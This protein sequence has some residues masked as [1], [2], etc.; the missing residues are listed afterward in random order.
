LIWQ[1]V[2]I[3]LF[4]KVNLINHPELYRLLEPGESIEDLLKLPIEQIL[5]RWVNYHLKNAGWDKKVN[6]FVND[7][8]DGTAY[9]VLLAQIAPKL[10]DRSPLSAPND[11]RRAEMVLENA[12]KL[13]CRKFVRPRDIVRGNQKLNL[14]FIANLFN[15]WPALEP[16]EEVIEIIEETREEKTFR[17]WMNSLGVNPFVNNLYID[18]RDGQ[19]LLQLF[20]QVEPGSVN[21]SK[22]N[23]DPQTTWKRLE[24]DNYAVDVGKSLKFSLVGIQGKDILDGNKTLTLAVVWQLMR[25]HVLSILRKL[26]GGQNISDNQI[27]EWANNKVA[28]S[29]KQSHMKSFKD[30]SL[31][32]SIFLIDLLDAVAPNSADYSLV[33]HSRDEHE[34]LLNAKYAVSLA[35]KIGCCVFALPEDIVE[36]KPKMLM[37]F[38]ATVMA[39]DLGHH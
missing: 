12:E 31:S 9:T 30:S 6:N 7:I 20:D 25:H 36:V 33:S 18:L 3:G 1:I 22:A 39:L 29:G 17:N 26:G 10:C 19:V 16:V 13:G 21:W 11:L 35:R 23:K 32:D 15:T 24:N 34:L 27:I 5:L 2:K 38:V 4:S 28:A 37:T 8:K 14:A